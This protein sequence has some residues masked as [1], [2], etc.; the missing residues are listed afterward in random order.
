M[1]VFYIMAIIKEKKQNIISQFKIN[2][3]DTGSE[4]VQVALLTENI[5]NL[6]GHLQKNKKDFSSKRGLFKMIS[7]RKK[8]LKYLESEKKDQ[9][10]ELIKSLGL[11]K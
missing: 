8:F 7:R 5:I 1:R 10:K 9:Y 6:T 4:Q 2:S 3:N 11:K